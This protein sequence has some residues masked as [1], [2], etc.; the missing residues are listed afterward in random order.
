MPSRRSIVRWFTALVACSTLPVGAHQ[1]HAAAG[2]CDPAV[3]DSVVTNS[4]LCPGDHINL[5]VVATGDIIGYSWEGP[6]TGT[7]FS[8]TPSYSFSFQLLGDYTIVVFGAC[9]NDTAV[10]TITAQGAGAGQDNMIQVC[11]NGPAHPLA[12]A[13]GAHAEGGTWLFNGTPHNGVFLPGV[14]QPGAYAYTS[15][16]PATCVGTNQTAT[17]TVEQVTIGPNGA[18]NLCASDSAFDLMHALPGAATG[19]DWTR[20]VLLGQ[21]P[22]SGIYQPGIDSSGTF[23]YTLDDCAAL[24]V[25]TEEPLLPWFEDLDGDGWGDP[26]TLQWSCYPLPGHVADSTDSCP[27][28]PGQVG[29][30]CDDQVAATVD[31]VL[32]DSCICAGVLPTAVLERSGRPLFSIWPNPNQGSTLHLQ[33]ASHGP[34]Q[35]QILDALGKSWSTTNVVFPAAGGP[36]TIPLGN[37][38]P[39]GWYLVVV[40]SSARTSTLPLL[41]Q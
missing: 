31:D 28:V 30:P 33:A 4:P 26:L 29:D 11:D 23:R 35:V 27:A 14:D 32:T 41:I 16:Y 17:I 8:F 18:W 39:K 12:L 19:G 1:A 24:V 9:G 21:E 20:L 7:F 6:G 2:S 34:A 36:L 25:V 38:L 10:V 37:G 40:T 3:I 5:S 22:H 15:P 13:L